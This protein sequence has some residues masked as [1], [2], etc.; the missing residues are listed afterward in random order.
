MGQTVVI[1]G[2]T[3]SAFGEYRIETADNPVTLKGQECE[4]YKISY[5]NTPMEETVLVFKDKMF[6][7]YLVLSDKLSVQYVCNA[8]SFGVEKI[9]TSFQKEGYN[10]SDSNL[11]RNE[12]FQQKILVPG[13][14]GEKEAI[15]LIA[16]YF[17]L[18]LNTNQSTLAVK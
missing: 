2:N 16:S 13:R 7:K 17:P 8:N 10:T 1:K 5:Q 3:N 12:Y 11:N 15:T 9:D 6:R 18:L 4:A 14:I